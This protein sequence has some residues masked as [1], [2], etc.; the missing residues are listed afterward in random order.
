VT[1]N[2][3]FNTMKNKF[4]FPLFVFVAFAIGLVAWNYPDG[5]YQTSGGSSMFE[6]A[7]TKDTITNAANDTLYLPSRLRPVNSDFLIAVAINRTSISGTANVAVKVEES[8]YPYTGSTPPTRGWVTS[9][10]T[11]NSSAATAATTATEET[12]RIPN[13]FGRSYRIIVDGTGTQSTSY[14]VRLL[15]KKKV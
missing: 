8:V 6:H 1:K 10:N 3:Y 14:D 11:A 4:I 7:Y 9:L 12:L 13:A 15:M 5:E 2:K